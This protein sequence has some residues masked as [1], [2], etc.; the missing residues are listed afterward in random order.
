M[1]ASFS[2]D[3]LVF[4]TSDDGDRAAD[5]EQG[6]HFELLG[7]DWEMTSAERAIEAIQSQLYD[8]EAISEGSYGNMPAT[9][10]VAIVGVDSA[11]LAQ[12]S[13]ALTRVL[14]RPGTREFVYLAPDGASPATVFDAL[15]VKPEMQFSD[16]R[17]NENRRHYL[18]TLSC[19]PFP[20]SDTEISTEGEQVAAPTFTLVDDVAS[21]SAWSTQDSQRTGVASRAWSPARYNVMPNG[22]ISSTAKTQ[23][24]AAG[25]NATSISWSSGKMVV[26]G[27]P[28]SSSLRVFANSPRS[29][30]VGTGAVRLRLEMGSEFLCTFGVLYRWFNTS[31][32]QVGSDLTITEVP[33][34]ADV[35]TISALFTPPAGATRLTVYPYTRFTNSTGG[36]R[37]WTAGK[38][39]I[40]PDGASF[41][42][43]TAATTS[44]AYDWTGAAFTS[45]S[46]ELTPAALAPGSGQVSV[47]GYIHGD[48]RIELPLVR[49]ANITPTSSAPYIVISGT[50]SPASSNP[51]MSLRMPTTS[52]TASQGTSPALLTYAAD[53]TYKAY[54]KA[55]ML[56][57]MSS[58]CLSLHSVGSNATSGTA[59]LTAT[60]VDLATSIPPIGT[61]RQGKFTLDLQGTMPAEASLQVANTGGVGTNVLIYTGPE[62]PNFMPALSPWMVAAGTADGSTI[63]NKKFTVSTTSPAAPTW[64]VP[65]LGLTPSTYALFAKVSG[66]G[67]ASGAA[68]TFTVHQASSSDNGAGYFGEAIYN[69]GK[70]VASG[71]TASGFFHLATLRLPTVDLNQDPNG[72]EGL[73]L[74]VSGGTWVLDEGWLLDVVNGQFSYIKPFSTT[75][76]NITIGSAT[77]GDPRQRYYTDDFGGD[78]TIRDQS[79]RVEIWGN[80]R[81]DPAVG[82]DVFVAC[83]AP[84][85][86]LSV[87]A[88]YYPRWDM[89]AAPIVTDDEDS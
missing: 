40:G 45:P 37:K 3:E 83:D 11:R 44:V 81:L 21:S 16:V 39:Y 29:T 17:E 35:H 12:G 22:L 2:C 74:W 49:A 84:A 61:G 10:P 32:A 86:D 7:D 25:S 50:L 88:S 59:T 46:V 9:V 33:R 73:R 14:R 62:N 5:D 13:A 82:A 78:G 48:S 34:T 63:S 19:K 87:S 15:H 66:S 20:R 41:W 23:G 38:V 26:T 68:Y 43:N 18:L 1:S 67:L 31:G 64:R 80:H 42:G 27:K 76:D 71:T 54:F 70:V 47:T 85:P 60:Q 69:T 58:I 30:L 89:F 6:Y 36:I 52:T 56:A 79:E 53:G 55:T 77:P 72:L 57:T 51:R 75:Y 65:H 8:G 4:L 24:W 28:T